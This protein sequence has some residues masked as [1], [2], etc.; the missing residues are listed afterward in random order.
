MSVQQ[1]PWAIPEPIQKEPVL[2][3]YNSLTKSK[4]VFVPKNGRRV[5]W[6]NCGP[7]VYD[8]SHMGHARNY[9]TQ[10]VLRRIMS[11]YFGYDIHFVMNITDIDD[12]IIKRAR[13]N[14]LLDKFRAETTSVSSDL[15]DRIRVDWRT[16][17]R[18]K[19]GKGL[20]DAEVPSP[21]EEDTKWSGIVVLA[22][23]TQWKQD[24]L[25]R[26]EKFDMYFSSASRTVAAVETAQRQLDAGNTSA[27]AAQR[28]IDDSQDV[29][30]EALDTQFGST[31]TDPAVSRSLATYWEGR[32]FDDMA[33]LRVRDPDTI[34]RVTEYVP[35]IVQFVERIVS[36]GYGYV[37]DGSVYFDTQAFDSADNHAYAKLEPWSKG[38]RELLEDGEGGLSLKNRVGRRSASDFA[39]WKASKEGE[40]SWPSKWGP[41]R[42]G[43]H[44]ECSVMASEILGD[45]MDIHS[46]GIDLAF[47][48]HDNE[49]AQSEAYH[50][51]GAWVNYFLHTG[52]LHIEGLKMSKSL[53]NFITVDEILQRHSARQLRLAFLTQLWNAK[54]DF[55]ESLMTGEV[56]N[57]ETTLNNFF[58]TVKALVSQARANG[59][60]LD[61]SH[62]Y[63]APEKELTSSFYE[64]RSA[65]RIAL[66]DSF[67]TPA[68]V[69]VLRDLVSQTNVYINS[70]GKNLNVSV[71]ENVASWVGKMLRMFG[72][73]EGESTELGWGQD[74]VEGNVN[75]EEVLMPYLRTLS[76]FRDGVRQLAMQK[77]ETALKDILALCDKLRDIDLVPL[78]VALD[79]QEDGKA[80]VKLVPPADL[81]KARD[82]KRAVQE[83]KA[84]KKAEAVAAERQK[85]LQ[86]LERGHL[87][88]W[89]KGQ[90]G[91]WNDDGIP[92]TDGEGKELSKNQAK[93]LQ[94]DWS[95]QKKL[96]EEFLAWQAAS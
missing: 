37:A 19:V 35:E 28:L 58:V 44:I 49:I 3:V 53:K 86:K 90:Y 29:L 50:E 77:S 63:D 61:G 92:L 56:R 4:D 68:A 26:D 12:K 17:V 40:P 69:D 13:Q 67:N 87:Q 2:K 31:V 24:C 42:P 51:C 22:Q 91:S 11:D 74:T 59:P 16:Y 45:N 65:F 70:R 80:L 14:H 94:K 32:F 55:S 6:Y 46:G 18:E 60:S 8:A 52:H 96:H 9:V 41:G 79:D 39:L 57:I 89:R 36:N 21:G 38:N 88:M 73:G 7:T 85:R 54:V 30:A 84:V 23:D 20:P 72:L 82:E 75:R 66:C 33:R 15:I 71:V 93:K 76:S 5:K 62:H 1:P 34:T 83:A 27:E 78:G 48:H 47:P 43:W 81:I 95:S 25:R 64:H 10:D